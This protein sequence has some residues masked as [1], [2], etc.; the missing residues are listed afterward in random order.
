MLVLLN[1]GDQVQQIGFSSLCC[2]SVL[3]LS[4]GGALAADWPTLTSSEAITVF[5]LAKQVDCRFE[6]LR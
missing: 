4:L 2:G 6:A 1:Y 5:Q 3:G